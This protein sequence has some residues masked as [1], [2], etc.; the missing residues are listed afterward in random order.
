MSFE[1]ITNPNLHI[2]VVISA[3][4]AIRHQQRCYL[5]SHDRPDLG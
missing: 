2:T 3:S 4:M 1:I 5:E